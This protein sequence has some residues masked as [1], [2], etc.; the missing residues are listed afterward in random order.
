[1][2]KLA[3]PELEGKEIEPLVQ[4]GID[5]VFSM[6]TYSGGFASWP[7][8]GEVYPWGS[9]Y[10]TH[11]L[12]EARQ[13]GYDV[14]KDNL[15]AALD[16]LAG[17][18]DSRGGEDPAP[19]VK[20][21]A[22]LVLAQA[23]RPNRSWTLRLY[24]R[25]DEL[26]AYSRF[27]LAAALALMKEDKLASDLLTAAALP[28][29]TRQ[30]DT[31]DLLHSAAREAAILLSV[32]LDLKQDHP[33]VPLLA[34]RLSD[35]AADGRWATTQENA[36]A[37]LALGKY[38]RR[39]AG[40][41]SD[42]KAEVTAGGKP[43]AS[44]TSAKPVLLKPSDIGGKEIRITTQGT[45]TL[46]YY[47]G[48]EGI[49][50][51]EAAEERDTSLKVRRRFLS[52]D[53]VPL[54]PRGIRQGDIVTVE[55]AVDNGVPVK[56]LVINDLLPACFEI[57]NP[58][59]ETS[60]ASQIPDSRSQIRPDSEIGNRQSAIGNALLNPER[61]EMRD[62]RLIIFADLPAPGLWRHRYVVRAVTAGRFKLPALN[63]FCMYN[64][65][66]C[67]IN[68]AGSVEVIGGQ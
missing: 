59:L 4:T 25:R 58:R 17:M 32:Y 12:A 1:M 56:N 42:F 23:G 43:L 36:F 48:A 61:V 63:A 28:P 50:T 65:E 45:G 5:R 49:P 62:D 39:I 3:E 11:F 22:C 21:Y 44:L 46:Y 55:L 60:G 2:A 47:W 15:D 52:R 7:G 67:S 13:A 16:Y 35:L 64:P 18:L 57:E 66:I 33:N 20:A 14:P 10:A 29:V 68:G 53:G 40:D 8:Y 34:K 30:R 41:K 27:Q 6:Q 24:E 38:A 37:L 19:P 31:G 51:K 9:V 54:D 26:P